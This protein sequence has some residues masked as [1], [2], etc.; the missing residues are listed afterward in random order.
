MQGFLAVA[1]HMLQHDAV[2]FRTEAVHR[3]IPG[4]KL[5]VRIIRAT[6]ENSSGFAATFNNVSTA[7][8]TFNANLVQQR[9]GV[10]AFRETRAS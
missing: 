2:A 9:L 6:V 7:L 10:T 5:A 3:F 8:R 4:S 1:I